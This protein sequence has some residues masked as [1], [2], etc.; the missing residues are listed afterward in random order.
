M[1]VGPPGVFSIF[2]VYAEVQKHATYVNK[3]VVYH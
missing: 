1:H 2:S 3:E